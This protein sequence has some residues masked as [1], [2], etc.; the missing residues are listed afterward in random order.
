MPPS[1]SPQFLPVIAHKPSSRS[2]CCWR[3][4]AWRTSRFWMASRASSRCMLSLWLSS[5]TALFKLPLFSAYKR[6]ISCC[7]AFVK[8]LYKLLKALKR[9]PLIPA[10]LLIDVVS[11]NLVPVFVTLPFNMPL[12]SV[13]KL[14]APVM[15]FSVSVIAKVFKIELSSFLPTVKIVPV[16]PGAAKAPAFRLMPLTSAVPKTLIMPYC[17]P[18]VLTL[19][20]PLPSNLPFTVSLSVLPSLS[21]TVITA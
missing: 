5:L 12:K 15:L 21:L 4:T 8:L 6:C 19:I 7:S 1:V 16:T 14:S 10:L 20:T 11:S 17:S 2:R 13:F 18:S 3:L 9:A